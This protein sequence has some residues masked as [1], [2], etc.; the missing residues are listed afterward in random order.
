MICHFFVFFVVAQ[1]FV[2]SRT[3]TL[4]QAAQL[5]AIFSRHVGHLC[6]LRASRWSNETER[7]PF[8]R[9]V[10]MPDRSSEEEDCDLLPVPPA[11]DDKIKMGAVEICTDAGR[12]DTD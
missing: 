11:Q 2:Q 6:T 7:R 10:M 1:V 3:F 12:D 5:V 8:P 9:S 4:E